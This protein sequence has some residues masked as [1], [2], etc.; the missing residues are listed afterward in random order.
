MSVFSDRFD[1]ALSD[2]IS[3]ECSVCRA[4]SRGLLCDS[5]GT[6]ESV[7]GINLNCLPLDRVA[8]MY[9]LNG[10]SRRVLHRVKFGYEA[11]WL[12]IF[13]QALD[14]SSLAL[15][16][17]ASI[18]PIPLHPIR[19]ATRGFNQSEILARMIAVKYRMRLE[20]GLLARMK[21]T[22]PQS[23]L[24]RT[25]RTRNV[26]HAFGCRK[27]RETP[28]SVILVDD[29]FTSGA[30]LIACAKALKDSGVDHVEAWTLF[31][32]P[33]KTAGVAI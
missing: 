22:P 8:S 25:V 29:V 17:R 28:R 27:H 2:L 5:C 13:R 20:T 10:V 1:S 6:F 23:R 14:L 12:G 7:P 31:R 11:R 19:L 24:R 9:W 3:P 18:V 4:P 15:N 30:T 16:S 26:R 33:L 32:T 21:W